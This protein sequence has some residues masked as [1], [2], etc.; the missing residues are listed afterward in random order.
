MEPLGAR[1]R[2]RRGQ[3]SRRCVILLRRLQKVGVE[4]RKTT[5][6]T[7]PCPRFVSS[8]PL[9]LHQ[10]Y[11]R[12]PSRRN[13]EDPD[14]AQSASSAAA[15]VVLFDAGERLLLASCASLPRTR[16]LRRFVSCLRESF[17]LRLRPE[18]LQEKAAL[19]VLDV[20]NTADRRDRSSATPPVPLLSLLEKIVLLARRNSKLTP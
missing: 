16:L 18:R 20:A 10:R 11:P 2:E 14:R 19:L 12:N 4:V 6:S 1:H 15:E 8:L 3:E 13:D 5:T 17:S 7:M 9:L